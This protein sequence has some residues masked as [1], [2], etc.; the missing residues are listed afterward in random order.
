MDPEDL[1]R[2][3]LLTE[4]RREGMDWDLFL[5]GLQEMEVE[6]KTIVTVMDTPIQSTLYPLVQPLSLDPNLG[7]L[8]SVLQL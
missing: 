7:I 2:E 1:Q 8:K 3:L 4:S 6:N 5:S